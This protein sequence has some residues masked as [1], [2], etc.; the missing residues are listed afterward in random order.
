MIQVSME[1]TTVSL[2]IYKIDVFIWVQKIIEL[3]LSFAP[4]LVL[5]VLGCL[6]T[7][8]RPDRYFGEFDALHKTPEH[9]AA[10]L[11]EL[12]R[13]ME[14][15]FDHVGLDPLH[16]DLVVD[17]AVAGTGWPLVKQVKVCVPAGSV[18][19]VSAQQSSLLRRLPIPV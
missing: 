15:P 6:W 13:L 10:A 9:A 11:A 5:G 1:L 12:V 7:P 14:R 17:A 19:L 2:Q 16:V 18:I 8:G 4:I 3:C